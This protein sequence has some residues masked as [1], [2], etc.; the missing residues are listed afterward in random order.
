MSVQVKE[1]ITVVRSHK[2]Q[3]NNSFFNKN[4]FLGSPWGL[5]SKGECQWKALEQV[6]DMLDVVQQEDGRKQLRNWK[7][8]SRA[9]CTKSLR[10]GT[11]YTVRSK[12]ECSLRI[13]TRATCQLLCKPLRPPSHA[14][15]RAR[16]RPTTTCK[17][18]MREFKSVGQDPFGQFDPC[19][20]AASKL[21]TNG[22]ASVCCMH[23]C[24]EQLYDFFSASGRIQAL[25]PCAPQDGQ[26]GLEWHLISPCIMIKAGLY[27]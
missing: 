19:N 23:I 15:W 5:I 9:K 6:A 13:R 4:N 10:V 11:I 25:H 18:M 3:R 21:E 17:Y 22:P 26:P 12:H 24:M 27:R 8:V 2:G 16:Y 1:P 14:F 7:C 20:L